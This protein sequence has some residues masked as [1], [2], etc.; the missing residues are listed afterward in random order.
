MKYHIIK[1]VLWSS[2]VVI[3]Y[4]SGVYRGASRFMEEIRDDKE[5]RSTVRVWIDKIERGEVAVNGANGR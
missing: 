1:F 3:G 5:I 4:M 2:L